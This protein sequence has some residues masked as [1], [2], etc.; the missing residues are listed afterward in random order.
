MVSEQPRFLDGMA[1]RRVNNPA[2]GENRVQEAAEEIT[3]LSPKT[4]TVRLLAVE[5]SL[6]DLHNKFDR[7]METEEENSHSHHHGMKLTSKTTNV[8]VKQEAGE[9][10]DTLET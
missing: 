6:G 1:G 3:V 5:E 9:Q 8:L 2:T 7:L 10:G 4:S